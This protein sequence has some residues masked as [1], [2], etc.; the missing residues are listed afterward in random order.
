MTLCSDP[1]RSARGLIEAT[2]IIQSIDI[3]KPRRLFMASITQKKF[4]T[5]ASVFKFTEP[6]KVSTIQFTPSN[7]VT[8]FYTVMPDGTTVKITN[9]TG[10]KTAIVETQEP[11]TRHM[12]Q[13]KNS[14]NFLPCYESRNGSAI[15]RL[16]P[17]YDLVLSVLS[18]IEEGDC[19]LEW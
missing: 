14:A 5:G 13:L 4:T 17:H 19:F 11:F 3:G 15:D 1:K 9:K 8:D 16:K 12:Y 18:L 10:I 2:L 7:P 6:Y